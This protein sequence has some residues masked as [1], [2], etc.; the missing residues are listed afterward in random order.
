MDDVNLKGEEQ[1]LEAL[2]GNIDTFIKNPEGGET[3]IAIAR[4]KVE[5]E[6]EALH[7]ERI[8]FE[9]EWYLSF[10]FLQRSCLSLMK[11]LARLP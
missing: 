4:K 2:H 10:S 9:Q 8:A 7:R 5:E 6:E 1:Q 11:E 3:T